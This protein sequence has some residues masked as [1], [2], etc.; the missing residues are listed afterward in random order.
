M[1]E[2]AIKN[3]NKKAEEL[4]YLVE[5]FTV[6]S[7]PSKRFKTDIPTSII[8]END[9]V[10]KVE[11]STKDRFGKTLTRQF[12]HGETKY[13]L[14]EENYQKVNLL[15]ELL[16]K[17]KEYRNTLSHHF[18]EK[19]IF[20]W[21]EQ[22][23]TKQFSDENLFLD[24]LNLQQDK[25]IEEMTIYF[26]IAHLVVE[27]PFLFCGVEITNISADDVDKILQ[28]RDTHDGWNQQVNAFRSKFQ[29]RASIKMSSNCEKSFVNNTGIE[30][31]HQITSLLGIYSG[32]V[33]VPHLKCVSN[34]KGTESTMCYTYVTDSASNGMHIT[35]QLRDPQAL[36]DWVLTRKEIRK[37]KQV[38]MDT[39]SELYIRDNLSS[40]ESDVLNMSLLYSK[41]AFTKDPIEKLIYILTALE[42]ILIRNENE[43]IMQNLADRMALVVGN[44]STERKE[45]FRNTKKVY[46][47]RSA[48]IH[49]GKSQQETDAIEIFFFHS[50]TMFNILVGNS[51]KFKT[52]GDFMDEIDDQKYS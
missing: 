49:H 17:Q 12:S 34:M 48:S 45:I 38:S 42:S 14:N 41:A 50:W 18:I 43:P 47:F 22:K 24:Y 20:D 9:I 21:I 10:G 30:K 27:E 16:T 33:I 19:T 46:G 5:K 28:S 32:A 7:P 37:Y 26:P 35:E 44:S 3:A 25:H 11:I 6:T 2:E 40:F 4:V 52:R 36:L 39:I 23:F 15:A 29:G 51:S 31:A 13:R 8:S 1:H